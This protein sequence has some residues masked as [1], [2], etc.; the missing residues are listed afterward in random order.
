MVHSL[1]VACLK[2]I[3]SQMQLYQNDWHRTP[4]MS[5]T[6]SIDIQQRYQNLRHLDPGMGLN[7]GSS[8]FSCNQNK[9]GSLGAYVTCMY[10]N[11]SMK[12][13]KGKNAPRRAKIVGAFVL[14]LFLPVW[15]AKT[16]RPPKWTP[17][18]TTPLHW[19]VNRSHCRTIWRIW[20]IL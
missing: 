13:I 2:Q 9:R 6:L 5:R 17:W 7:M 15:S 3:K 10:C 19:K 12:T 8:G 20:P 1:Q 16:R 18:L 14:P 11:L 4:D